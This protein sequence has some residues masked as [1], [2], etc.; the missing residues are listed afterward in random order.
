MTSSTLVQDWCENNKHT[1]CVLGPA[2]LPKD[3]VDPQ[4]LQRNTVPRDV[5]IPIAHAPRD[6]LAMILVIVI[7]LAVFRAIMI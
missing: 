3:A 1:I 6:G 4:D 5:I 2:K 7:M